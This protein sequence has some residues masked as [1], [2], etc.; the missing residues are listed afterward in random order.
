MHHSR[1][2]LRRA[3]RAALFAAAALGS[4]CAQLGPQSIA[5]GRAAYT[6]VITRTNDE[7][8]L[9]TLVRLRYADHVHAL[10]TAVTSSTEITVDSAINLGFGQ[11]RGCD[12][13]LV[14]FSAGAATASRPPSATSR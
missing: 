2:L 8:L 13:N 7:Q 6:D 4:S 10:V 3:T 9:G 12:G 14:P 11:H 5:N 1:P